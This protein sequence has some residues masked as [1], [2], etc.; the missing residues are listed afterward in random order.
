VDG[1]SQEP[2]SLDE[3]ESHMKPFH[4][5]EEYLARSAIQL[6]RTEFVA[7]FPQWFLIVPVDTVARPSQRFR[8][9]VDE[10]AKLQRALAEAGR[11]E[12]RP[13]LKSPRWGQ[14]PW[15]PKA[16]AKGKESPYPERISI[17][18]AS[19]VDIVLRSRFVSKLHAHI[20]VAAGQNPTVVDLSSQNGTFINNVRLEARTPGAISNG[21]IASFGQV[22]CELATSDVVYYALR[23]K[24]HALLT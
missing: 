23:R 21:D 8:T 22:H 24:Y 13:T 1:R 19:N 9:M 6:D 12:G 7:R 18:R 10:D 17:G 14:Q 16:L 15:V 5:A 20:V 2:S 4:M 3:G 11:E